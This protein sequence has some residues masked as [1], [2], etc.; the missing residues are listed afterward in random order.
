M[1][2]VISLGGSV[3]GFP[4]NAEWLKGFR[5]FVEEF[6]ENIKAIVV[7]GG[8]LAREMIKVARE[9]GVS[10]DVLDSIGIQSTLLNA[11]IVRAALNGISTDFVTFAGTSLFGAFPG[12]IPVFGGIGVPGLTTDFA[13]AL[14]AEHLG[15]SFVNITRVGGIYNKNPDKYPDADLIPRITYRDL[16]D[17]V[18]SSDEREPGT[19]FPIDV[20]AFNILR[21]SRIHTYIVGPD[22]KNLRNL[23]SGKEWKGTEIVP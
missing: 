16:E 23:F 2:A 15:V 6:R 7:G 1:K 11:W 9:F 21:R 10:K 22:L 13:A 14:L 4:P 17:L 19:N 12:K 20:A 8:P 18:F 3:I 5:A